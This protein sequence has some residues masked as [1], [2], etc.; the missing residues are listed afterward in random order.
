M[1]VA[2]EENAV[3]WGEWYNDPTPESKDMPAIV[4]ESHS[5]S[6]EGSA[7]VAGGR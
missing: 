7:H 2:M 4:A 1:L 5:T 6:E 3:A